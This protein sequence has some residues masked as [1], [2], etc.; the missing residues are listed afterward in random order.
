VSVQRVPNADGNPPSF[1]MCFDEQ[2]LE[3][4]DQEELRAAV[5][6]ELGHVW[7][8]SHFPY[9]Q[10]EALANDIAMRLVSRDSLKKIYSKLWDHLGV[11]GKL[12][13]FLRPEQAAS[14]SHSAPR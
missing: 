13:D 3:S 7:I 4:L 1:I 5:A 10:T 6:H 2:F 14:A 11:S 12:D 8:Y 9:L